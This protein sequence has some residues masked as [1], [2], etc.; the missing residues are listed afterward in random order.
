MHLY[1]GV[2]SV[3]AYCDALS[4]ASGQ[5]LCHH[6]RLLLLNC[7]LSPPPRNS[8]QQSDRPDVHRR[9]LIVEQHLYGCRK[10]SSGIKITYLLVRCNTLTHS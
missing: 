2:L 9:D 10:T 6:L 3:V 7:R 4:Q 5:L 1:R 8:T